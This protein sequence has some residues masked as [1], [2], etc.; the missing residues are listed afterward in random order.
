[1]GNYTGPFISRTS[2]RTMCDYIIQH[3]IVS[4]KTNLAILKLPYSLYYIVVVGSF[5]GMTHKN[6]DYT[7]S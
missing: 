7:C 3:F 4:T 2:D 6:Y 1:M 5:K